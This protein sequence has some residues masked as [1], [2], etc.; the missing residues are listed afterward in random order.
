MKVVPCS[1][2]CKANIKTN[3]LVSR[4]GVAQRVPSTSAQRCQATSTSGGCPQ[5]TQVQQGGP[6]CGNNGDDSV[7][8]SGPVRSFCLFGG[9]WTETGLSNP[10]ELC[11]HNRNQCRQVATVACTVATSCNQ[12]LMELVSNLTSMHNQHYVISL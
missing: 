7:L 12:L 2:A 4:R 8:K 3:A 10:T 9:N 1:L 6:T 11:N 5:G